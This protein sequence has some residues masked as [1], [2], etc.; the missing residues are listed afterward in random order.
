[1]D[2]GTLIV[3]LLSA[4]FRWTPHPYLGDTR[5]QVWAR[6]PRR[7]IAELNPRISQPTLVSEDTPYPVEAKFS[8]Q[9]VVPTL[10]PGYY[11]WQARL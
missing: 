11:D 1:M 5:L 9:V 6:T 2:D 3:V 10:S 7:I 4:E 8:Y